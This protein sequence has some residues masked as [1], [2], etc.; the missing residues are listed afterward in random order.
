MDKLGLKATIYDL[1][2]YLI[3]GL[4]LIFLF[5]IWFNNLD[6]NFISC[7]NSITFS[8]P[9]Y[10]L[11]FII[12]YVAGH[13]I[14]SFSSFLFESKL[15]IYVINKFCKKDNS[16]YDEKCISLFGKKFEE[17]ERQLIISYCQK[18]NP[19][20]Y[21]T[22]FVFLTI[23]GFSR[24]LATLLLIFY[25]F[26]VQ[27]IGILNIKSF[28]IFFS[29]ILLIRNYYRFKNYYKRKINSSLYL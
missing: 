23:Y 25:I 4:L 10:I 3:P 13:I 20:I 7:L 17:C 22:A 28:V 8:A 16:Q 14:S 29:M 27:K 2:G 21:D 15:S 12:A 24:N 18:N 6:F 1:F 5:Y 11:T 9:F 26:I 19:I